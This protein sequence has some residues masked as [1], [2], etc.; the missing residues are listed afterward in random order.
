[1]GSTTAA[2]GRRPASPGRRS[3]RT[4]W[5]VFSRDAESSERSARFTSRSED[6]ASRLNETLGVSILLVIPGHGPP[7][8]FLERH[9]RLEAE[10]LSRAGDIETAAW[11][12]VGAAR[13]EPQF[14]RIANQ[15]GDAPGQLGDGRLLAGA[16]VDR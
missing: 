7:Q 15:T 16:D 5:I 11:L 3:R 10:P 6:S 8:T 14:A 9:L 4:W 2:G 13:I 12:A 1:A